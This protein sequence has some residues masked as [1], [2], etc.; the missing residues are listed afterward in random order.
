MLNYTRKTKGRYEYF[1]NNIEIVVTNEEVINDVIMNTKA[2]SVVIHDYNKDDSLLMECFDFKSKKE[3]E[4]A[5]LEYL[6]NN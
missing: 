2:W 3:A 5:V 6:E 1:K 4:N